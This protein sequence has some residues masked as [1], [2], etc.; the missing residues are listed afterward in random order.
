MS[1]VSVSLLG[2]QDMVHNNMGRA[3]EGGGRGGR[4]EEKIYGS[5]FIVT[6]RITCVKF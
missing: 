6:S 2:V 3:R 1:F 5:D 4:I